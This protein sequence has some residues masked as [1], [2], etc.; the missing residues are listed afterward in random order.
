V[1]SV[2]EVGPGDYVKIGSQ[3][4]EIRTNSAHNAPYT[5]REWTVTTTDG[6]T[7]GMFGIN[8]YAKKEERQ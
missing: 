3:W 1:T 2:T 5:P 6:Q 4:K 8:A 7:H